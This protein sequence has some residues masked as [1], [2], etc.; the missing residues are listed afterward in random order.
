MT[1]ERIP[2]AL[3]CED[4][5]IA[6]ALGVIDRILPMPDEQLAQ[7]PEMQLADYC[8]AVHQLKIGCATI[9]AVV[10]QVHVEQRPGNVAAA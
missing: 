1:D 10:A 6:P 7:T 3:P 8:R 4:H 5:V 9:A 2:V